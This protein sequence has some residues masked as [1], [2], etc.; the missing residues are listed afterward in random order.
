MP[1]FCD[2][3]SLFSSREFVANHD[4]QMIAQH[5]DTS[6]PQRVFKNHGLVG[7]GYNSDQRVLVG[8]SGNSIYK[9]F[10]DSIVSM[11]IFFFH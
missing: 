9:K 4:C 7:I 1:C 6:E 8:D 5:S 3:H 10:K 11:K 2:M